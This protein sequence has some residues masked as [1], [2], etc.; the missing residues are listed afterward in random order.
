ML[1]AL[2]FVSMLTITQSS[3]E[4]EN[5]N[6]ELE[7]ISSID[8]I[9]SKLKLVWNDEFGGEMHLKKRSLQLMDL[10]KK[11]TLLQM[12]LERA[13]NGLMRDIAMVLQKTVMVNCNIM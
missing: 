12:K 5:P 2:I 4:I 7:Q 8:A 6:P 11:A 1:S 3:A 9:R 13:L 10:M